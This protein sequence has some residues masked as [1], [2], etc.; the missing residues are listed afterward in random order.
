MRAVRGTVLF[1]EKVECR[2][3]ATFGTVLA[4]LRGALNSGN[5]RTS[6]FAATVPLI[7]NYYKYFLS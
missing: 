4:N 7:K 2:L 1:G 5:L 6:L 3:S